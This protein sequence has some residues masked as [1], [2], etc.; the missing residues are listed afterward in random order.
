MD[1]RESYYIG[2]Y[3]ADGADGAAYNDTTDNDIEAYKRGREDREMQR[4]TKG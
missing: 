1:E 3:G 4:K 2:L